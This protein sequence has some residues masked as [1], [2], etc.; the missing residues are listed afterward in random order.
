MLEHRFPARSVFAEGLFHSKTVF[1]TGGGSGIGRLVADAFAELGAN[2]VIAARKA[3]RLEA[4]RD[5]IQRD[6]G[7]RV[8]AIVCDISDPASVKAAVDQAWREFERID[9]VINNAG[10]NTLRPTETLT[11]VRWKAIVETVL[12]GAYYVTREHAKRWIKRELPGNVINI[13][14]TTGWTGKIGRAHV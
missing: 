8:A 1:L 12:S 2:L 7:T 5:E 6:W 10:A 13:A 14:S 11:P 4:A 3:E 9:V